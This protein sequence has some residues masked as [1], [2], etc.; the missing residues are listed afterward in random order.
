[1]DA[2]QFDRRIFV[3]FATFVND[4]A[5]D[6]VAEWAPAFKRWA[7]REFIGGSQGEAA[8]ATAREHS[9]NWIL[10]DDSETRAMAPETYRIVYE[11]RPYIINGIAESKQGRHC[12]RV[13]QTSTRPDL[14]GT[15]AP[16]G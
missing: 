5:G 2:G 13:V 10:R 16:D 11:G 14:R 8:G 15:V 4:E 12:L 6:P 3:E 1:M 7:K 9:V